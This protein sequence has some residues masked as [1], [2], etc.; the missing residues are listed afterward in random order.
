M[1]SFFWN[2]ETDMECV[3]DSMENVLRNGYAHHIQRL[4]VLGLLAL[5]YGVDPR[6]FH[7]WHMAMY[8]DAIDWVSA[9]NTVG[10]SQYG[11]GGIVG[12]KPYCASGNYISRMS[13]YCRDC[14]YNPKT[15]AGED[16][17]PVTTFYWEFLGRNYDKLKDNRRMTF[18]LKNYEKKAPEEL[19][20]AHEHAENLR[21]AWSKGNS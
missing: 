5:L 2:G 3:R 19:E 15:S 1:P 16:A 21:R 12:T 18:Q 14:R 10:M 7:E 20:A 4:M 8:L 9:P 6:K 13:N 17:C 11:D